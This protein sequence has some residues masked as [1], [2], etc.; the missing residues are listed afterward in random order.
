MF[1]AGWLPDNRQLERSNFLLTAA[2]VWAEASATVPVAVF[3]K[4]L[5]WLDIAGAAA[6][7]RE[8]GFDALDLTVRPGGHLEPAQAAELPQAAST[9]R[10]CGV[11]LAM[12]TTLAVAETPGVEAILRA[13]RAAGV[14]FYR[15]GGWKYDRRQ[16]LNAQLAVFRE[17]AKLLAEMNHQ[18]WGLRP[19][20]HP[21]R[22]LRVW[23]VDLGYCR[24]LGLARSRRP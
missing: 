11:A 12:I 22:A 4:H 6:F 14:R 23:R 9:I 2:S 20:S 17:K 18:F 1:R 21:L 8:V 24:L 10:A 15:W 19:L 16:S 7:A 13:C 5:Q 3:S